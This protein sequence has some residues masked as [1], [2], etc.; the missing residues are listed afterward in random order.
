MR[1]PARLHALWEFKE[2]TLR[3]YVVDTGRSPLMPARP[4]CPQHP[5]M[6]LP[7]SHALAR[8]VTFDKVR[9]YRENPHLLG[10]V[11]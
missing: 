10:N 5:S 6:V 7:W 9:E 1:L 4:S 11:G 8:T 2:A 3:E